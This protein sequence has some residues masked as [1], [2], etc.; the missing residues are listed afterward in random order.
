M[1]EKEMINIIQK[2]SLT[3]RCLPYV[4]TSLFTYKEGQRLNPNQ[5]VHYNEKWKRNLI[6]EE[7]TVEKG[8]WWYVKETPNTSSTVTFHREYDFFAPTLEEAIQLYLKS[9]E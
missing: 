8:G 1:K 4:V 6:K 2:Y 9:K 7:R 5:T 3:V